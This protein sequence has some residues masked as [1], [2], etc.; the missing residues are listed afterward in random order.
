MHGDGPSSASE[1]DTSS[2]YL[3]MTLGA[4][5]TFP[6]GVVTF[7]RVQ[8]TTNGGNFMNNMIA[9][10]NAVGFKPVCAHKTYCGTDTQSL[11]IG[12]EAHFHHS[13]YMYGNGAYA[14]P[15]GW[16][17]DG[18][19]AFFKVKDCAYIGTGGSGPEKSFCK[20]LNNDGSPGHKTMEDS[21][22][23]H[24]MCGKMGGPPA[25]RSSTKIR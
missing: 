18:Y 10:C 7:T 8:S 20:W 6:G 4:L 5:D 16:D 25:R 3:T 13:F 22:D 17:A 23:F 11:F 19:L 15:S 24:Y 9:A 12:Q 14:V 1:E 2:N 21:T